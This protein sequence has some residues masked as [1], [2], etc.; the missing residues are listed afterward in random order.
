VFLSSGMARLSESRKEA[1]LNPS[2]QSLLR[3]VPFYPLLDHWRDWYSLRKGKRDG[4]FSQDGEDR[5]VLEYFSNHRGFYVDA[6][7]NHPFRIS[8][9]YLL[10]LNGWRGITIE[11]MPRLSRKHRHYRPNDRHF[12]VGAGSQDGTMKLYDL[13]P[14]VLT[15]FDEDV[16]TAHLKGGRAV[17]SSKP[18]VPIRTIA[19]LCREVQAQESID[20]LNI[21]CEGYD[22]KVL[23][24]VDWS[25]T[26]PTLVCVE[27]GGILERYATHE[28][29]GNDIHQ[30]LSRVGYKPLTERGCNTFFELIR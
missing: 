27:T 7:A 20:F 1:D 13:I 10:Y 28:N 11:P 16:A 25:L 6:G 21:D 18:E 14:G 23:E 9:T 19:S 24:G 15:T 30:F 26:K 3:A 17:L 29:S 5:F 22:L 8:N 12:N 4:T 2:T